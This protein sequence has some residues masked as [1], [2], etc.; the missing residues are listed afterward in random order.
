[1]VTNMW[2][3][4]LTIFIGLFLARWGYNIIRN[5]FSKVMLAQMEAMTKGETTVFRSIG[6][7]L[8]LLGVGIASYG[9]YLLENILT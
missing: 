9:G 2:Y 1:M 7:V 4:I 3:S 5:S 8:M 6:V